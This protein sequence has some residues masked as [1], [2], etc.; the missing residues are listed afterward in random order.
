MSVSS[1]KDK[2]LKYKMKYLQAKAMVGGEKGAVCFDDTPDENECIENPLK[3]SDG[4]IGNSCSSIRSLIPGQGEVKRYGQHEYYLHIPN[5][6]GNLNNIKF[7]CALCG[8]KQYLQSGKDLP[9][10]FELLVKNVIEEY[11]KYPSKFR[12]LKSFLEKIPESTRKQYIK[13][14]ELIDLMN[15][16]LPMADYQRNKQEFNA[17]ILPDQREFITNLGEKIYNDLKQFVEKQQQQQLQQQQLQYQ[18]LQQQQ[19]QQQ[20][21]QQQQRQQLTDENISVCE[22]ELTKEEQKYII[23]IFPHAINHPNAYFRVTVED[24]IKNKDIFKNQSDSDF[25]PLTQLQ[26]AASNMTNY[27]LGQIENLKKAAVTERSIRLNTDTDS[28]LYFNENYSISNESANF[29]NQ[30]LWLI[31][32]CNK[33]WYTIK[34]SYTG[35]NQDIK[36]TKSFTLFTPVGLGQLS[37]KWQAVI[38]SVNRNA[39][40]QKFV[41]DSK[42]PLARITEA[43]K[44]QGLYNKYMKY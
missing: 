2:Y 4:L 17:S 13:T 1:Y 27:K 21:L 29:K 24:I 9:K 41:E 16:I 15:C 34:I 22:L 10:L 11:H 18:Q 20:Q 23:N 12:S 31:L 42:R 5:E 14:K 7:K 38:K 43:Q 37:P 32:Y 35:V 19:L 44:A 25:P 40:I 3:Q 8:N 33:K 26:P 39:A 36:V 30:S 6:G 28:F